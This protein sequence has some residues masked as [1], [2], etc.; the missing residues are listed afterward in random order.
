LL[1]GAA[2]K[3]IQFLSIMVRH[4]RADTIFPMSARLATELPAAFADSF[5]VIFFPKIPGHAA[6]RAGGDLS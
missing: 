2:P 3:A 4:L 5:A 6:S 1:F